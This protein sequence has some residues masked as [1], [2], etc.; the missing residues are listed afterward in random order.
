M[1]FIVP[2]FCLAEK[3]TKRKRLSLFE[4]MLVLAL[5]AIVSGVFAIRFEPFLTQHRL[6]TN[7]ARIQRQIQ[8]AEKLSRIYQTEVN[9]ALIKNG[10]GIQFSMQ[11]DDHIGILQK[12]RLPIKRAFPFFKELGWDEET[13]E[14]VFLSFRSGVIKN[15]G[16]LLLKAKKQSVRFPIGPSPLSQ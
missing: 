4:I 10:A 9:V 8:F 12:E 14:K 6:K 7:A 1:W 16:T 15:P 13:C 3:K 11:S 5:V 2:N